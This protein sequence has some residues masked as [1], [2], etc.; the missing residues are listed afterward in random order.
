[1][2]LPSLFMTAVT[3]APLAVLAQLDPIRIVAPALIG[4]VVAPL[5]LF[6][7]QRYRDSYVSARHL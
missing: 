5:A 7:S 3:P 6:A 2:P 4:L 1:M